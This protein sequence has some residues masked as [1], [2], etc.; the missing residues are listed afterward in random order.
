MG[1]SYNAI[2]AG[3]LVAVISVP[4]VIGAYYPVCAFIALREIEK[5]IRSNPNLKALENH[6]QTERENF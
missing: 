1:R 6:L 4:T 5:E 3:V 2:V